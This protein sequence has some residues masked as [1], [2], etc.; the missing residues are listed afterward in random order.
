VAKVVPDSRLL[1]LDRVGHVAQMERPMVV[2]R[3]VAAML[4][5]VGGA[6]IRPATGMAATGMAAT[7]MAATGMA[8]TGESV[9][10]S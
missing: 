8:A 5:E 10:L 6:P 1:I 3:A 2:A 9:S 4:D 7:G